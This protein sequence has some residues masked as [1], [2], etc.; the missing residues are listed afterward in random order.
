[1][2]DALPH[3]GR[4]RPPS[5]LRAKRP[6]RDES[7]RPLCK[8]GHVVIGENVLGDRRRGHTC[9]SCAYALNWANRHRLF[10]DDPRVLAYMQATYERLKS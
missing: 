3:P 5:P 2:T 7:G 10:V 4:K 1:M 6:E 9:R 8:R